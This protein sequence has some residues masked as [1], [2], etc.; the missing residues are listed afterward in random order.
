MNFKRLALLLLVV[1]FALAVTVLTASASYVVIKDKNGVCKVIEAKEKTPA[2]IAGPFKTKEEAEK[3]KAK[4]CATGGTTGTTKEKQ[5]GV[6]DKIKD[7][8]KDEMDKVK[9]K[10]KEKLK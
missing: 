6:V 1:V 7:K 8:A 5:S 10:A 4:E 2:T 3:A 9:E